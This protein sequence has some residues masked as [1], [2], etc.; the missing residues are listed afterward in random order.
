MSLHQL[1]N[2]MDASLGIHFLVFSRAFMP[3]LMLKGKDLLFASFILAINPIVTANIFSNW[4]NKIS[5]A[6]IVRLSHVF[7][8]RNF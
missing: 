5:Q 8:N 3:L 7:S 6:L 1:F 4:K 2:L